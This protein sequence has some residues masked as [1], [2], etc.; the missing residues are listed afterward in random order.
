MAYEDFF[1]LKDTPFRLSPDPD[2]YFPS[3]VHNEA[4]QNLI[5]SIRSG[6]GFVQITGE[7]GAGKTLILRTLLKQLGSDINTALI[8]HPRLSGEELLRTILQDL[9]ISPA[10]IKGKSKEELLRFFQKYL[11]YQAKKGITTVVIIDESQNLPNDTLE[12]LRLISNLETEKKKL[13]QIILVGQVELEEKLKSPDLK[14]FY[15]RITIRYRLKPLPKNDMIDYIRHRLRLAGGTGNVSFASGVLDKIYKNSK[16]F[17]RLINI[18]CER[19]LMAA[20][21]EN[22][23]QIEKKHVEKAME[24]V[25]GEEHVKTTQDRMQ[26]TVIFFASILFIVV[27]LAGGYL[28]F[29]SYKQSFNNP[30]IENTKPEIH[31]ESIA[32]PDSEKI[33]TPETKVVQ[34]KPKIHKESITKPGSE[35]IKT[36][37]T[38]IVQSKPKIYKESVAKPGSEESKTPAKKTSDII[39]YKLE[40][41][42]DFIEKKFVAAEKS[43]SDLPDEVFN[44]PEKN[45][46]ISADNYK[47]K[48]CLWQGNKLKKEFSINLSLKEG[49]FVLGR[50]A[51]MKV[52][53]FNHW[54]P[55]SSNN[56]NEIAEILWNQVSEFSPGSALPIIVY[57]SDKKADNSLIKK[58]IKIKSIIDSWADSWR[59]VDI[60]RYINF[61]GN[62]HIV[63]SPFTKTPSVYS[64]EE[65][66]KHKKNVFLR[67]GVI[68]LQ[69][70]EPI[71]I[72]DPGNP[73]IAMALFHQTYISSLY[74]DRGI[75]ALYFRLVHEASGE[76]NWKIIGKLWVSL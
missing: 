74:S 48:L 32:N 4:L 28:L 12:E 59:A 71:C 3:N 41:Q 33:K 15:Q 19:A 10:K 61:Y 20:F 18:I 8:L 2:Y 27:L 39:D 31:K 1:G 13:L 29:N 42:A 62:M 66:Y 76:N 57:S 14:Q 47:N 72:I 54:S 55:F 25:I 64:K 36:P 40:K 26:K 11:L 7:P 68:S 75:K 51:D 6:E 45:F 73:N 22:T 16:G 65:F 53:V 34:S 49:L 70:S 9:G 52:F 17:P 69:I 67:S 56:Y 24:S 35:K 30:V 44:L 23:N 38:K 5:Y 21:V 58:A 37:K 50:D 63:F 43:K 60:D 46:F